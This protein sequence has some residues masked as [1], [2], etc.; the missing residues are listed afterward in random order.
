MK[1]DVFLL[2]MDAF[3][4]G[5]LSEGAGADMRAHASA[6]TECASQL[7]LQAIL[8][9][10]FHAGM[11]KPIDCPDLTKQVMA[12]LPSP[13]RG[14]R[15]VLRSVWAGGFAVLLL[16][17]GMLFVLQPHKTQQQAFVPPQHTPKALQR[18]M[19]MLSHA[20]ANDQPTQVQADAEVEHAPQPRSVIQ[21]KIR[22]R[23]T[24]NVKSYVARVDGPLRKAR[25]EARSQS[26]VQV[27]NRTVRIGPD[28][29]RTETMLV[30]ASDGIV[31]E[32]VVYTQTVTLP[33]PNPDAQVERPQ[34][35]G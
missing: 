3:A 13:A 35:R 10:K 20:G 2:R 24:P 11:S 12:M 30:T 17:V 16:L 31:D 33:P 1:C 21:R 22:R 25:V 5:E 6:C 28:Q 19:P 9:F 26:T 18:S 7:R 23:H 32:R 34:L 8:D 15:R 29:Y 14:V 27:V 4:A